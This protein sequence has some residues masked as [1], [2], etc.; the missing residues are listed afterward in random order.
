MS[1]ADHIGCRQVPVD[2]GGSSYIDVYIQVSDYKTLFNSWE[3]STGNLYRDYQMS[4]VRVQA[5]F[6]RVVR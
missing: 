5:L 6:S 2:F 1:S 4:D 3:G